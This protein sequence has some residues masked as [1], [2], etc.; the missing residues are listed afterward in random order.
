MGYPR[1]ARC[2]GEIRPTQKSRPIPEDQHGQR[3]LPP[4]AA[5][6]RDEKLAHLDEAA[7]SAIGERLHACMPSNCLTIVA[8][9][10]EALAESMRGRVH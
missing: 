3:V 5:A 1:C 8:D 6:F 10:I 4:E 2:T 7:R 9:E